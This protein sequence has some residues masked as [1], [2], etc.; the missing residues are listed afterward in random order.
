MERFSKID[1]SWAKGK[2]VTMDTILLDTDVTS[3][4][5]KD[6]PVAAAFRPIVLGNRL[7]VSFMALAEIHEGIYRSNWGEVKKQTIAKGLRQFVI[8]PFTNSV[9]EIWGRIRAER[10]QQ[11]ISVGDAWIAATAIAYEL[12]LL[13]NNQKHFH[14]IAGLKLIRVPLPN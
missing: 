11:P 3:Y 10:K 8:L 7:A 5:I 2:G 1:S 4:I 6:L 14:G 12:P 13:T 9:C